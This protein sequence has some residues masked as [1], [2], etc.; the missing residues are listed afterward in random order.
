MLPFNRCFVLNKGTEV[1]TSLPRYTR[2]NTEFETIFQ[3]MQVSEC[4]KKMSER[5]PY[6]TCIMIIIIMHCS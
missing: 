2:E 4:N 6:R 5:K 1:L 3:S